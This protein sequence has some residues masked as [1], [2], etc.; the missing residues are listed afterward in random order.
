MA[1]P[2]KKNEQKFTYGDYL[3][4]TNPAERWELIEGIAYDMSPA[5]FRFHQKIIAELSVLLHDF[6]VGKPCEYYIAPF[7]VRLPDSDE[8]DSE[9][10]TVVQPDIVVVCDPTKLDDRGM[11]GAPDLVIEILSP[12]TSKKDYN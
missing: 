6:L 5:P 11:R 7:D 9:I 12:S 8:A 1:I 3:T 4:W 10:D 2:L